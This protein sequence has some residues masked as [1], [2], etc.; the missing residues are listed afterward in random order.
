MFDEFGSFSDS[1]LDAKESSGCSHVWRSLV[2]ALPILQ[3][4]YCWRVSNGSS[5]RVI[6]DRWILNHPTNNVSHPN[7]DFLVEMDVSNLI[8]LEIHV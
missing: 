7:H 5:I 4:G 2:A 1:F 3:A 8:N 6:G